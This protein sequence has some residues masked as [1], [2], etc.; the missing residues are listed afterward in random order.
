M[1]IPEIYN[2]E[3]FRYNTTLTETTLGYV[4]LTSKGYQY[5]TAFRLN[6]LSLF[7]P[8][9]LKISNDFLYKRKCTHVH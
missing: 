6:S 5:K 4:H 3:L 1:H 7:I 2:M 8:I 9:L